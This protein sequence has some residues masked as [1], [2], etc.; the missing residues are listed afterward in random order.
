MKIDKKESR[1][2]IIQLLKRSWN[3]LYVTYSSFTY[4]YGT[5]LPE[6]ML[7]ECIV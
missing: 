3:F 5:K 6:V 7:K 2:K 1:N 4:V